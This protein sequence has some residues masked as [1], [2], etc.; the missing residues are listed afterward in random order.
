MNTQQSNA[1]P[2]VK[3]WPGMLQ[4]NS[5]IHRG[6]GHCSLHFWLLRF[7]E[8]Y[9]REEMFNKLVEFMD[10]T[11]IGAYAAY[12]LSGE[13]DILLRAW[14]PMDQAGAFAD[15]LEGAFNPVDSREFTV[16]QVVRHWPWRGEDTEKPRTCDIDALA[17]EISPDDVDRINRLSDQ[18]HRGE[19]AKTSPSDAELIKQLMRSNAIADLQ[20]TTG[21]RVFL[22][23]K[24]KDR[25]DTE[26][27]LRMTNKVACELDKLTRPKGRRRASSESNGRFTIDEVSLYRCNDRSLLILCR[28]PYTNWHFMRTR[29]LEP[30]A[31]MH[32]ILQTTTL[33]ALSRNFVRSRN[34]LFLDDQAVSGLGTPSLPDDPSSGG[35]DE[36]GP[37]PP[38][39]SVPPGVRGYLERP[40][41]TEFEAKGSAFSPL[42]PWLC[43]D[44][45]ATP[46]SDLDESSGFFRD[47]IAR[48]VVAMLNTNGGVLVIGV[49]EEERFSRHNNE[50]LKL[51]ISQLPR[52]G[53]FRVLGLQDPTFRKRGWDGFDL[54]F[55]RL[56]KES[57]EGEVADLVRVSRHWHGRQS[58]ALVQIEYPG[59]SDGFWLRD[60]KESR[61]LIRRGGSTDEL[62]GPE[63]QRYI[64]RKRAF[65]KRRP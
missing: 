23:L 37:I 34:H 44:M 49:L 30:L 6:W 40:E 20:T 1:P 2:E 58:V 8:M 5:E 59:M 39:P 15:R 17:E 16:Q 50:L 19:P 51:R 21:I 25:V 11:R 54:K 43:R 18:T 48:T 61:F 57:I 46:E 62:R 63:A 4:W 60:G 3:Q 24:V 7:H 35:S 65:D 36:D 12:E 41:D 26:D 31:D 45:D 9:D 42:E 14:I 38:P 10:E 33:P 27:W 22:R 47:T 56:L 53:R 52:G 55:N 29:L 28:V 32:G 13:F 64:K